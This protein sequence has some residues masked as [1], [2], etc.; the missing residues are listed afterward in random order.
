MR[1]SRHLALDLIEQVFDQGIV[2]R[3]DQEMPSPHRIERQLDFQRVPQQAHRVVKVLQRKLM[4]PLATSDKL[5]SEMP[6]RSI[7]RHRVRTGAVSTGGPDL[8]WQIKFHTW[9]IFMG[10]EL[11]VSRRERIQQ[12]ADARSGSRD[13]PLMNITHFHGPDPGMKSTKALA[14][15]SGHRSG[16]V[17]PRRFMSTDSKT[18]SRS[19]GILVP[20]PSIV[21]VFEKLTSDQ[22]EHRVNVILI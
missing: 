1:N 12:C 4:V 11:V 18:S 13:R 20:R 19:A 7:G 8:Q 6:T 15:D 3:T 16:R 5:K 9:P 2:Q 21:P 17:N 14:V 22:T 10:P